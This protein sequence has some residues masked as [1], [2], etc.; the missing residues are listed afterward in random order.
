MIIATLKLLP[1]EWAR[2]VARQRHCE[3]S[4]CVPPDP[5]PNG[6]SIAARRASVGRLREKPALISIAAGVALYK[7][8]EAFKNEMLS[9]EFKKAR[10]QILLTLRL[11]V[12]ATPLPRMNS[13]EMER[14]CQPLME[15]LW[16]DPDKLLTEAAGRFAAVVNGNMDRDYIH[17]Q[18]VTNA[19]L[20]AFRPKGGAP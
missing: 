17:T 5:S 7:I 10:Y 14:R 3:E 6:A 1:G 8:N 13:N 15:R 18:G 4:P 9:N 2:A 16:Q 11:L 20:E 12:N 19:I